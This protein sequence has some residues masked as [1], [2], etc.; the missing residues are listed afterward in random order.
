MHI[1]PIA[2][3]GVG[4]VALI[5]AVYVGG[6]WLLPRLKKTKLLSAESPQRYRERLL[7]PRW[8]ELEKYLGRSIPERIKQFYTNTEVIKRHDIRVSNA[9][10]RTYHVA[11]FLPADIEALDGIWPDVKVS[12]NFPLAT[13]AFGDCFYVPLTGDKSEQCPVMYYHH[14]GSDSESVST[15]LDEFLNGVEK[16]D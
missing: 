5:L 8:D 2:I 14:D 3:L 10:G 15:S 13:D 1:F 16:P 12:A 4:F 7:S 6:N 9:K 11:Q